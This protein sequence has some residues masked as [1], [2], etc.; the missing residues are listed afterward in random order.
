M[1]LRHVGGGL[2]AVSDER[3]IAGFNKCLTVDTVAV[4]DD[5]FPCSIRAGDPHWRA[6]L[7]PLLISRRYNDVA[8]Q[9]R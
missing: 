8:I 4:S 6:Q 3:Q 1:P 9:T 5:R 2:R 7:A